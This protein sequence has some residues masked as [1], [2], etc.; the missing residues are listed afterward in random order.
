MLSETT[1]RVEI[2]TS[3]ALNQQ[4]DNQLQ[5]N[6][7]CYLDADHATIDRRLAELDRE[8]NVERFIETEAPLMIGLGIALGLTRSRKWFG[9]SAM[10]AGMVILHGVQGWY[11][12]LPVFRRLGVRSQNEIE[13]ERAALRV[14]RGDHEAYRTT[15]YH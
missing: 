6:L 11:P 2:N 7:S 5:E 14:L 4:F 9:L 13:E 10:A 3:P 15:N 1:Q 12:L 8:W